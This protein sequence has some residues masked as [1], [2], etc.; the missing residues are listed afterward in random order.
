MLNTYLRNTVVGINLPM[1]SDKKSMLLLD[2]ISNLKGIHPGSGL[3]ISR[4]TLSSSG[5]GI[6]DMENMMQEIRTLSSQGSEHSI[7]E[8]GLFRHLAQF[9]NQIQLFQF[10]PQIPH[11]LPS[12]SSC[13]PLKFHY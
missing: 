3:P 12:H 13:I 11:T 9:S 5:L 8:V 2:A 6:G 4:I 10:T 7:F 1:T